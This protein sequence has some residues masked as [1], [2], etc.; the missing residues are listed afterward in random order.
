MADRSNWY[1]KNRGEMTF[2]GYE[3]DIL[4]NDEETL[5][6]SK[7]EQYPNAY[8]IIVYRNYENDINDRILHTRAIIQS[9]A[10]Y[11]LVNNSRKILARKSF[12]LRTGDLINYMDNTWLTTDWVN[13]QRGTDDYSTL[14]LCN[15]QISFNQITKVADGADDF[16]RPKYIETEQNYSIPCYY[17]INVITSLDD[18][19]I[20]LPDN[21]ARAYIQYTDLLNVDDEIVVAG[22]HYRI[23]GID[24]SYM[25][26]NDTSVGYDYG[27]LILTLDAPISTT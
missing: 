26:T 5:F 20:N 17:T 4:F 27:V 19:S 11:K 9:L 13:R 2:S 12:G 24:K 18:A 3:K 7:L 22:M 10:G 14:M 23:Y 15:H 1:K 8:D 6:E 25:V 21:R 16:G